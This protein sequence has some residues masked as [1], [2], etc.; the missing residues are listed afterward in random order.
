MASPRRARPPELR[1]DQG[2]VTRDRKRRRLAAVM[3]PAANDAGAPIRDLELLEVARAVSAAF[4]QGDSVGGLTKAQIAERVDGTVDHALLERR[5]EVFERLGWLRPYLDKAHQQR[6]TLDPAGLVGQQV[7]DRICE[8]G[9]VDELLALL[10]R[11]RALLDGRPTRDDLSDHLRHLRDLLAVYA[12]DLERL[13][14][15]A[16]LPELIAERDDHDRATAFSSLAD[17]AGSITERFPD[18]RPLATRTVEEASRYMRAV[19]SL[20]T[21]ILDEGGRARDFSVLPADDYLTA[22]IDATVEQLAAAFDTVVFD[23]P[24]PWAGAAEILDAVERQ[25]VRTRPGRRPSAPPRASGSDP[26]GRLV[27]AAARSARARALAAEKLLGGEPAVEVTSTIQGLRWP[28]AAALLADLL[29]LDLERAQPYRA[30]IGEATFVDSEADVTYSSPVAI[31]AERRLPAQAGDIG[32][33]PP[34][35]IP[36]EANGA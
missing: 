36:T 16:P 23:P 10:D 13:V 21:R 22:A 35:S 32:A 29:A 26:I 14:A 5:L 31:E 27:A 12:D 17:A 33:D 18:L 24:S 4:A 9:G 7:F 6:Y 25:G 8:R 11:T 19:E 30:R 15:T 20:I 2:T 34:V 3:A 28:A 1:P